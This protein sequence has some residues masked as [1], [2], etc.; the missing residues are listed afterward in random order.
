MNVGCFI[1]TCHQS[2]I[3]LINYLVFAFRI[4]WEVAEEEHEHSR[5]KNKS[6]VNVLGLLGQSFCLYLALLIAFYNFGLQS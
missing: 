1:N 2:A 3:V 6:Q 5:D 4:P